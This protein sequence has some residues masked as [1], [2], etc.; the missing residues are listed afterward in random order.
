MIP[1]CKNFDV[2]GRKAKSKRSTLCSI[3]FKNKSRTSG[4]KSAGREGGNP[5]NRGNANGNPGNRGNASGNPGNSGNKKRGVQ[6]RFAGQRSGLSRCAAMALTIK[7][8]WLDLIL[9]GK[10]TWEIRGTSTQ[11]RGYIHFAESESGQLRERAKLVDCRRLE[12]STFMQFQSRHRVPDVNM[13]KYKKYKRDFY[14]FF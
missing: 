2:C 7:K 8:E 13:V 4:A 5:G 9:E 10:K 1:N 12:H 6:K 11:R 3:C 14:V